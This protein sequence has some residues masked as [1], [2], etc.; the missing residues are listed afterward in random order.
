MS[1]QL[2]SEIASRLAAIA[3]RHVAREYPSKPDHV[4]RDAGDVRSPRALHPLFH[5][6]FDWH[7]C[8]HGHWL[9]ARLYRRFPALPETAA[10]RRRLDAGFTAENVAGEIAY[11]Q[12]PMREAFER[13]YGWAWLLMLAAELSRHDSD[14][15]QHWCATLQPLANAFLDRFRRHLPKAT[16]PVRAGTHTNSA[17]ALVLAFE[18]ARATEDREFCALAATRRARGSSPMRIAS[19]GSPAAKISF[20]QP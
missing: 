2:T 17:F 16:Y 3:L 9:L 10:I 5:G 11:L 12:Q 4:L 18:Y 8:V 14:D 20:P 15:G 7:S 6:S 19:A 13:P 1:T